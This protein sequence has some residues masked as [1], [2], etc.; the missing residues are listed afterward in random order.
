MTLYNS[1]YG[2][3]GAAPISNVATDVALNSVFASL[4]YFLVF[5]ETPC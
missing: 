4:E 3:V 1:L 2:Y 5:R